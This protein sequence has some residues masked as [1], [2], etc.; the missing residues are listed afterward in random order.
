MLGDGIP[1]SQ[2]DSFPST[3]I[4]CKSTRHKDRAGGEGRAA[5]VAGARELGEG[6]VV[7]AET[8]GESD[9][10]DRS[11]GAGGWSQRAEGWGGG[12]GRSQRVEGRGGGGGRSRRRE[13][14]RWPE[15]EEGGA[16]VV[17]AG[18]RGSEG[19]AVMRRRSRRRE[20]RR[21]SEPGRKGRWGG[22]GR[23][24]RCRV[25]PDT[26]QVSSDRY[27]V[28]PDRYHPIPR[29]YHLICDENRMI[30]DRYHLIRREYHLKTW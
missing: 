11:G 25:S 13:Q 16:T 7:V 20:Q 14:Q 2:R 24:R 8:E 22:S 10:G 15:P 4:S 3:S 28:I 27:R 18:S 5:A 6:A 12:G 9:G 29:K 19:V 23:R 26:S 17:V 1:L 30:P 21:W